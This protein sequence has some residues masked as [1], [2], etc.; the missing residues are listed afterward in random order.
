MRIN[1]NIT[2]L[3]TFN[4]Y[5]AANNK[6]ADSVAKLSSGYSI[7]SA[8][9]NAAGLAISEKMRAQIRGLDTASDNSQSAISLVQTAEGALKSTDEIL[10]RMREISVQS[11]S[12]TNED[13]I[14]RDALQAEFSQLQSEI[15]EISQ[16]S[17]FNNQN[18]LDGSL[19][20]KKLSIGSGTS[21]SGSGMNVSL[22]NASAG[23]YTFGVSV[24]T[25]QAEVAAAKPTDAKSSFA[26]STLSSSFSDASVTIGADAEASSL[27]N[28]NYT[29]SASYDSDSEKITVT[30]TGDNGQTFTKELTDDDFGAITAG[31]TL[32]LDFGSDSFN[33]S[34]TAA[35]TLVAGTDASTS[36]MSALA[37]A[38]GGTF[39]VGG[40]SDA[41]D[42]KTAVMASLTGAN[43]VE[44]K[45]GMDSVTFDN[46]VTV[47]FQKL[48]ASDLDTTKTYT[49]DSAV[50]T[51]ITGFNDIDDAT[52]ASSVTL[53]QTNY[54][55]SEYA[56][57][58]SA[59]DG[60]GNITVTATG[61][62]GDTYTATVAAGTTDFA[63]NDSIPTLTF[64]DAAGNTAFAVD[65]AAGG[66]IA[67]DDTGDLADELAAAINGNVSI[68]MVSDTDGDLTT[69]SDQYVNSSYSFESAFGTTTTSLNAAGTITTDTGISKSTIEVKANSNSGLTI[70]VGANTGDELEINIDRADSEY[71]GVKGLDVSTQEGASA[72]IDAVN[73]AIN[74]VSSQRAYLGAIENRL[75]YKID[76]LGT[77]SQNL[78]SAESSIR[79][80]DMASE[81]TK[82]T[83]ANILSQ[84]ATAML[85]Q[86]NSLPQNVLSLLG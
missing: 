78:T 45:A 71:L 31:G 1:T 80:V 83:N 46:G 22:G 79:D 37:N 74:Q 56:L 85:A 57:S 58:S 10:Q 72:A 48:T 34:L 61:T 52:A 63:D 4:S 67:D 66:A 73:S 15:D 69:D 77:S 24:V 55:S 29:L 65:L 70:Q 54:A 28:G 75:D 33:V 82:F 3:N 30:A 9:D 13:D 16:D 81:M 49:A 38:I 60:D 59:E 14:D 11:S 36:E 26:T 21:L 7:N 8:A 51:T 44:L 27:L 47:S 53:T 62:N 84:A 2:A 5:T 12:D 6:I 76:N 42:E 23:T 25:T 32:D 35:D 18:L 19:S 40:G 68:K 86:A 64:K 20:T 41:V 43:S 39:T 50:F 17:T